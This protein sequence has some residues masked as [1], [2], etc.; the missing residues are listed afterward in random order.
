M[1]KEQCQRDGWDIGYSCLRGPGVEF[2][3]KLGLPWV[4]FKVPSNPGFWDVIL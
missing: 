2:S 1:N 3:G 4:G